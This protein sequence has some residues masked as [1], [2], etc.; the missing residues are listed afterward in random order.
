MIKKTRKYKSGQTTMSLRTRNVRKRQSQQV[1]SIFTLLNQIKSIGAISVILTGMAYAVGFLITNIY[2]SKYGLSSF[3]PFKTKYIYIGVMFFSLVA[4]SS[5]LGIVTYKYIRT[6]YNHFGKIRNLSSCTKWIV[7]FILY[8]FG[9]IGI[10][11]C[12]NFVLY[13]ATSLLKSSV[14]IDIS[15]Y[16]GFYFWANAMALL[17]VVGLFFSFFL[18]Q[19]ELSSYMR[20]LVFFL[21]LL[22]CLATYQSAI[23]SRL[24]SSLGGG[25]PILVQFMVNDQNKELLEAILPFQDNSLSSPVYLLN[26]DDNLYYIESKNSTL[27]THIIIVDKSL[28]N[29]I[30]IGSSHFDLHDTMTNVP[31]SN[32]ITITTTIP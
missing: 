14:E 28:V 32:T 24:P 31:I 1:S 16:V 23:F 3:S 8:I 29:A 2:L 27:D 11:A 20:G 13:L 30:V 7:I 10:W 4:L 12:G 17:V 5:L 15:F 19:D 25:K 6:A 18:E 9:P 22:T 21:L 26:Q